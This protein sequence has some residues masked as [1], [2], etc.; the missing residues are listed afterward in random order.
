[1]ALQIT[2]DNARA[3]I[4]SGKPV[5]IDFWATW[6]AGLDIRALRAVLV[7]AD[8]PDNRGDNHG[9]RRG[10]LSGVEEKLPCIF[11]TFQKQTINFFI[12]VD[13]PLLSMI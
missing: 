2:D 7:L 1:M 6:C 11:L 3:L 9:G 13:T 10:V 5:I 8:L 12:S 4:E